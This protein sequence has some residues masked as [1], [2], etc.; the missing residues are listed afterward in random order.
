MQLAITELAWKY[1]A[2]QLTH[3]PAATPAYWPARQPEQLVAPVVL[4]KDPEAQFVQVDIEVPPMAAEY[5]PIGQPMHVSS[6]TAAT[7]EE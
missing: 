2:L 1:P 6:E 5:F 3:V 4:T 7:V